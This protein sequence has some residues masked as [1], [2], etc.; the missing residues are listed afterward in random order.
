MVIFGAFLFLVAVFVVDAYQTTREGKYLAKRHQDWV[1]D[2]CQWW[3]E[4]ARRE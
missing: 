3:A 4:E 1:V 2:L